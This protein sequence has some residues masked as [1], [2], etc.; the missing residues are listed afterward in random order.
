MMDDQ[1]SKNSKMGKCE[2]SSTPK[3]SAASK[4]MSKNIGISDS[5]IKIKNSRNKCA[6]I[7]QDVHTALM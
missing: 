5:L 3:Y 4:K 6:K 7:S 2:L 1:K